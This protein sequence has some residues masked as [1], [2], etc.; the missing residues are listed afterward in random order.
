VKSESNSA[1]LKNQT[2]GAWRPKH[3]YVM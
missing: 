1:R 3:N 2:A